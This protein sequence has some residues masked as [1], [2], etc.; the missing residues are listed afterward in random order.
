MSPG[1]FGEGL[2]QV[3][4]TP[5]GSRAVPLRREVGAGAPLGVSPAGGVEHTQDVPVSQADACVSIL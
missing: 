3:G 5:T 1:S 2:A 4:A